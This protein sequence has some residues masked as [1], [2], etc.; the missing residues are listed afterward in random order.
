MDGLKF[1]YSAN[2]TLV[3][4]SLS[5]PNGGADSYQVLIN[6]YYYGDLYSAGDVW[7]CTT[8]RLNIKHIERFG[9]LIED[10]NYWNKVLN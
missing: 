10:Q 7:I 9:A 1:E 3:K 8:D 4:V 2:K 5:K 6:D